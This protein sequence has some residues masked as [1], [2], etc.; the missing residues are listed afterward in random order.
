[1]RMCPPR[2]RGLKEDGEHHFC[3]AK[4]SGLGPGQQG[5]VISLVTE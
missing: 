4:W 1:M 5:G 3:A 2:Q